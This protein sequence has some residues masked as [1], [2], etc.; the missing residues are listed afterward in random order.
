MSS[1]RRRSSHREPRRVES[2][3]RAPA[4][5]PAHLPDARRAAGDRQPGRV[6]RVRPQRV[7]RR[8]RH[9]RERAVQAQER[10]AE[11]ARHHPRRL[12]AHPG[13]QPQ[14]RRPAPAVP[15]LRRPAAAVPPALVLVPTERRRLPRD[16]EPAGGEAQ[17]LLARLQGADRRRAHR[18]GSDWTRCRLCARRSAA[19]TRPRRSRSPA[20]S[21]R[22]AS[23]CRSGSSILMLRNLKSPETYFQAAFRVQS[24]WSIKNPERRRPERRGD[25]QAG[26]LTCS[27]SR[28]RE[29]CA[30]S[31]T[32]AIGLSP[33]EPTQRRR[34]RIS[35]RSCPCSPTTAPT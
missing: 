3:R 12:R 22:P 31:P 30:S 16:G 34:S 7:L 19:A 25:P 24:P 32:T 15:V 18:P 23:R 6:R 13:R 4:D 1:G 29:R 11:V 2:L 28:R 35:C 26:L 33:D 9:R 20:A 21:S 8:H 5:A 14:A 17:H 10:R 27:T